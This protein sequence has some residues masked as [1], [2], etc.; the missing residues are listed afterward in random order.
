M[1]VDNK[2]LEC[3]SSL[4]PAAKGHSL[5][6]RLLKC[7]SQ[8]LRTVIKEDEEDEYEDV[9]RFHSSVMEQNTTKTIDHWWATQTTAYPKL[10]KVALAA[11]TCFYGS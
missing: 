3:L 4:D 1:P 7:L 5:S 9:H 8:F 2:P 11:L 10:S 6:L